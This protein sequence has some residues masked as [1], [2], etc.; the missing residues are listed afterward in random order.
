ME[1]SGLISVVVPVYNKEDYLPRCFE[2]ILSQ[3]YQNLEILLVDDCSTDGS[4][5]LCRAFA[6]KDSRVKLIERKANGGASLARNDALDASQGRYIAFID[7]DDEANAEMLNVLHRALTEAQ[8][9]IACC[10][11]EYVRGDGSVS[12]GAGLSGKTRTLSHDEAMRCMLAEF[13][14][15]EHLE[16]ANWNKLYKRNV[17]DGVRFQKDLCSE[18]Y[19]FN[20][21]AFRR[22][23][24]V[25][26]VGIPL[27]RNHV[28]DANS[29]SRAKLSEK[30]ITALDANEQV[31]VYV[32]KEYPSL[33]PAALIRYITVI[34]S[35]SLASVSTDQMPEPAARRR[36][37]DH[38]KKAKR[39]L[40]AHPDPAAKKEFHNRFLDVYVPRLHGLINQAYLLYRKIK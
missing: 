34:S 2:S 5:P 7:A 11:V 15:E 9:D 38:Y 28:G 19:V 29:F 6:S 33:L 31:C 36:I 32:E 13:P 14:R 37:L 27:Y 12:H 39:I 40:A 4:L 10:G 30:N 25:A 16:I 22:A 23:S 18:D 8:A 3:T 26:A 1:Q 21:E 24:R 17:L 35:L 20:Y